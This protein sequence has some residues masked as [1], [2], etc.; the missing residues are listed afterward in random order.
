LQNWPLESSWVVVAL[1]ENY[2]TSKHFKVSPE[3]S[4]ILICDTFV[5]D[6]RYNVF[7]CFQSIC[8]VLNMEFTLV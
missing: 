4:Q 7:S 1:V 5:A 6:E 8:G 3:K 2:S